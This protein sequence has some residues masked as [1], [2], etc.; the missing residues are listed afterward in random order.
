ML[1][2]ISRGNRLGCPEKLLSADD[3][4]LVL[5]LVGL[6]GRLKAG[7]GALESKGLRVNVKKTKIMISENAGKAT[8]EGK[9][10]CAVCRKVLG[11][12]FILCQVF[13]CWVDKRFS[14]I[15]V[16]LKEDSKIKCQI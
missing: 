10:P 9:F 2:A 3:V 1:E 11:K 8:T 12:N 13:R 16:K 15:R 7:K 14:G 4:A 6:K 5:T